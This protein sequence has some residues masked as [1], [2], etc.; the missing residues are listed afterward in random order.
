LIGAVLAG[1]NERYVL[2]YANPAEA[3]PK[4]REKKKALP[5]GGGRLGGIFSG[6]IAQ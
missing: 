3:P 2:Q 1:A 6:S 5:L 4:T